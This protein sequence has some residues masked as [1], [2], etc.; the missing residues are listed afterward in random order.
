MDTRNV[1]GRIQHK[2]DTQTNWEKATTFV[3]KPGEL[4]VYD[5]DST[6]KN[7][8]FKIG[9]GTN[10]VNNLPFTSIECIQGDK[11]I[12]SLVIN[13]GNATGE[14]SIAGG[15]NDKDLAENLIGY[16]VS[17]IADSIII[18][19]LGNRGL[20][21]KEQ[22]DKVSE[23]EGELSVSYGVGNQSLT[24]LSTTLGIANQAGSKGFYLFKAVGNSDSTITLILSTQQIGRAHV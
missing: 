6:H 23:A 14:Y 22:A 18:E 9:D 20:F 10:N 4:I 21:I 24:A 3:P 13:A 15:T 11:N 17:S 8:R 7:P 2:H 1:I 12:K 5:V 16:D 19:K